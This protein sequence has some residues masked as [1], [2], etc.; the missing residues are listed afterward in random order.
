MHFKALVIFVAL[1]SSTINSAHLSK[2]YDEDTNYIYVGGSTSSTTGGSHKKTEKNLNNY[3][4]PTMSHRPSYFNQDHALSSSS[5]YQPQP[6]SLVSAN[7]QLLEPFMLAT[8]LIFVLSLIEKARLVRTPLWR[9]DNVDQE[10]PI[11]FTVNEWKENHRPFLQP[12]LKNTTY[13]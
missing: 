3:F 9:R 7:I 4:Y 1:G 10:I 2:V 12:L 5:P 11:N 6:A 8:F 13:F